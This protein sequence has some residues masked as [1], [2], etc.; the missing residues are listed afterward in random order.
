MLIRLDGERREARYAGKG[1][2]GVGEVN[3][4]CTPEGLSKGFVRVRLALENP[5][6]DT[7]EWEAEA[8]EVSLVNCN[9]AFSHNNLKLGKIESPHN[10]YGFPLLTKT[11]DTV[12]P[13]PAH[14][15]APPGVPSRRLSKPKRTIFVNDDSVIM[16]DHGVAR[17]LAVRCLDA[18][19]LPLGSDAYCRIFWNGRQV[20]KTLPSS[21]SLL[22]RGYNGLPVSSGN[23]RTAPT[24]VYQRNPVWWTPSSFID[25]NG[26]DCRGD[27]LSS[28]EEGVVIIPLHERP[29]SSDEL[30]V[31]IFDASSLGK[32][33]DSGI[34]S[35]KK[36]AK[37]PDGKSNTTDGG[38]RNTENKGQLLVEGVRDLVG[39]SLGSVTIRGEH[40]V[41]VPQ[42]RVDMELSS[43][44]TSSNTDHTY[45]AR[46]LSISLDHLSHEVENNAGDLSANPFPSRNNSRR[47][48]ER[49]ESFKN[50]GN[51]TTS[52]IPPSSAFSGRAITQSSGKSRED[53]RQPK[54]WLRIMLGR[55]RL[56]RGL[57]L[58]GTSDPFCVVFFNR[59][60][61]EETAVCWKTLSP[62]WNHWVEIEL[63]HDETF[64][65][66]STAEVRVE[67]W[68][69]D[70]VGADDF[71]GEVTL[72]LHEDIDG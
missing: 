56:L 34:E 14:M 18:R 9:S 53:G 3:G 48:L 22:A 50:A 63:R 8:S 21:S 30:V 65:L 59:V 71:I 52:R 28:K 55:A 10:E 49:S 31:E 40:L 57:D 2:V 51:S 32:T 35:R 70:L 11:S 24:W 66:G 69:K 68:D 36:S 44:S 5:T 19:G 64:A 60:W 20:G 37:G 58:S 47:K 4:A 62:R 33:N 61:R 7:D 1:G 41:C 54:R 39:T 15:A 25:G 16:N 23:T 38:V 46:S 12:G 42:G 29:D 13:S 26:D 45:V 43:P 72:F 67:V 6:V 27:V 17:E